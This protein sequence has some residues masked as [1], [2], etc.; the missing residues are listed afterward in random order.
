MESVCLK[1]TGFSFSSAGAFDEFFRGPEIWSMVSFNVGLGTGY[2][3]PER[4]NSL[5]II[6]AQRARGRED[7]FHRISSARLFSVPA[8]N[9]NNEASLKVS[10]RASQSSATLHLSK[11][12][13]FLN[14]EDLIRLL[15]IC[16]SIRYLFFKPLAQS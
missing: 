5:S 8:D 16:P 10:E 12:M 3:V 4:C 2:A 15:V 1:P 7:A 11:D 13:L 14:C 9:R 6:I